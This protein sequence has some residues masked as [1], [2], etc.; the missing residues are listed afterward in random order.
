MGVSAVF[1]ERKGMH[2][3]YRA[4]FVLA[5]FAV[6]V[7]LAEVCHGQ[8]A[9]IT[10]WDRI[11]FGMTFRQIHAM[12]PTARRDERRNIATIPNPAEATVMAT[13]HFDDAGACS[14]IQ[15]VLGATDQLAI[16]RGMERKYGAP[17]QHDQRFGS[18]RYFWGNPRG[19]V[20][21]MYLIT[22]QWLAEAGLIGTRMA[23]FE[24]HVSVFYLDRA[25]PGPE[26]AWRP[27]PPL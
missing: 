22:R 23:E 9:E 27:R 19:A 13:C 2:M 7:L 14:G 3:R 11:R 26:P 17:S 6:S 24:G 5:V 25:G 10:G 20:S 12:Y 15:V 8:G 21:C 18:E 4:E 1:F 16:L